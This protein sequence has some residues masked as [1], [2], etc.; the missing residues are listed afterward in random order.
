MDNFNELVVYLLS[1]ANKV[2]SVGV[3]ICA[4]SLLLCLI[5]R[6]KRKYRDII[7]ANFIFSSIL[8]GFF[9]VTLYRNAYSEVGVER[10]AYLIHKANMHPQLNK[11]FSSYVKIHQ[12]RIDGI[13][14]A[15][16]KKRLVHIEQHE[17]NPS[18][19]T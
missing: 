7:V 17:I 13:D 11:E 15:V 9:V 18:Y 16:L 12:N 1:D 2:I 14:Y 4:L 3:L 10:Y 6:S 19:E 8:M 5:L